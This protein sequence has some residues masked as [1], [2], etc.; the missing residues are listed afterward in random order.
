MRAINNENFYWA[1]LWLRE[2]RLK[3][4]VTLTFIEIAQ[5]RHPWT[6]NGIHRWNFMTHRSIFRSLK[7]AFEIDAISSPPTRVSLARCDNSESQL[8]THIISNR[9][10]ESL[11]LK[12]IND[13]IWLGVIYKLRSPSYFAT[14]TAYQLMCWTRRTEPLYQFILMIKRVCSFWRKRWR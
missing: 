5:F 10:S 4:F 3:T 1:S 7:I 8:K 6:L 11:I 12:E 14:F 9:W 13:C 2:K